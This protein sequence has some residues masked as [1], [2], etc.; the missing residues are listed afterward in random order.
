MKMTSP[1]LRKRKKSRSQTKTLTK[2]TVE[3]FNVKPKTRVHGPCTCSLDINVSETIRNIFEEVDVEQRKMAEHT[4]IKYI[5][6]K[7]LSGNVEV[8]IVWGLLYYSGMTNYW[9]ILS[10]IFTKNMHL[11]MK[12]L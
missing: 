11:L 1:D 8:R 12:Q 4:Y 5:A 7:M 9:L 10:C 2:T 6:N 3:A